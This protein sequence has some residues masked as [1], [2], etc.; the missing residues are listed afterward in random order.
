[1]RRGAVLLAVAALAAGCGGDDDGDE[2]GPATEAAP[3]TEQPEAQEPA[4]TNERN[5]PAPSKG[6]LEGCL[7]DARLPLRPGSEPAADG[8]TRQPL[9]D[10]KKAYLGYVQWPSKHVADVYLAG[11]AAEA[12]TIESEAQGF[13]K[14]FGLDPAKY[15]K[16]AGAVVLTFDDPPPTAAEVKTVEDC[17]SGSAAGY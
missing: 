5:A 15:V 7:V 9:S 11:D 2:S 14:A 1:M 12:D 3:P 16:R 4:Q 17:A 10:A 8:R 6:E 13:I